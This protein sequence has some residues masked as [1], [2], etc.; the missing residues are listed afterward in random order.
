[1]KELGIESNTIVFFSSDNGPARE[2]THT[3]EFFRSSGGL[4]G[5]K[6]DL[7]EGGLRVPLIARQPGVVPSGAV[8]RQP[9]AFW[10]FLPTAAELAGA[11]APGGIDGRS[12]RPLLRSA[13]G[14][15]ERFLYWEQYGASLEQAARLG[16]WKAVSHDSLAGISLYDLEADPAETADLA[17]RHAGVA[18]Q[19]RERMA[20]AHIP[21]PLYRAKGQPK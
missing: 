8:C 19:M 9:V 13:P 21:S 12:W 6:G 10:D 11:A 5:K 15:S 14:A 7:Y 1:L 20:H 16:K 2:G 18:A 4:R 3:P 17:A